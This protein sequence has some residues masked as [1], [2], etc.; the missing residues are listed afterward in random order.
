VTGEILEAISARIQRKDYAGS[1][2]TLDAWSVGPRELIE[3]SKDCRMDRR[4][5]D[6][7]IGLFEQAIKGGQGHADFAYLYE[8][9]K[10][11]VENA[12]GAA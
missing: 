3:W 8:I 7:Q 12:A 11:K 9:F 1:E 2:A 5:A 4:I 6:A 10:R